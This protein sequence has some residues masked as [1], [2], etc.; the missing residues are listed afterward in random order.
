MEGLLILSCI[1]IISYFVYITYINE[2]L[3]KI[4]STVDNKEYLVQDKQ[5]AAEAA[6]LIAEIRRKLVMLVEHLLKSHPPDDNRIVLLQQNFNADALREVEDGSSY[7]SYSINKGEKIVLC[8]RNKDGSLVNVNTMMFVCLHELAHVC[9]E[10][11]GHD[12]SFWDTFRWILEESIN[13]GI[14][15]KQKFEENPEPYCGMII[16]SSPLP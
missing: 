16:T 10:T 4:K 1:V 8:L 15:T 9:N 13:I 3:I 7:T 6:N 5:D 12:K 14:Y 11:I 2:N